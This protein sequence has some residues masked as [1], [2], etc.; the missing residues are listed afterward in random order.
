MPLQFSDGEPFVVGA[1]PYHYSPVTERE[2]HP[3]LILEIDI[4]GVMTEAVVDTGGVYLL[5]TPHVAKRLDLAEENSVS[6]VQELLF[7][8][9]VVRGRL[10]RLNLTLLAEVGESLTVEVTAFVPEPD[11]EE[12]WGDILCILGLFGCLERIRF[13]VDP[14]TETFYLGSISSLR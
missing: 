14:S 12:I 5:C 7:R 8:G 11:E 2:T 1:T 4:E 13:A 9:T 6:A 3:R 10:H